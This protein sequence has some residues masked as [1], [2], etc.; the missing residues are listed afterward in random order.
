MKNSIINF[1][2]TRQG[3]MFSGIVAR[4]IASAIVGALAWT[5]LKLGFDFDIETQAALTGG[6]SALSLALLNDWVLSNVSKGTQ[7]I[8]QV[9]NAA[10]VADTLKTDGVPG[11]ATIKAARDTA[12]EAL[13]AP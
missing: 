8:Q 5:A 13:K 11:E 9:L 1:F 7:E 10:G 12:S 4:Y 2:A 3:G 6:I